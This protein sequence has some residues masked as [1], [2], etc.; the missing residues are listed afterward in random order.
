MLWTTIAVAAP[1]A[2]VT[3]VSGPLAVRKSDDSIKSI[4]IGS[5][6]DEGDTVVTQNRTYARLKFVDGSEITLKPNSQFSVESFSYDQDKPKD[7]AAK[8]SLIKGGLRTITGQIGKRVNKDSYKMKT[9]A[10]TIGIRGTM[11]ELSYCQT[12]SITGQDDGCGDV[13]PGLYLAV[14]DG[15]VVITNSEGKKTSLAVSAGQHVYV[16]DSTTSPV[17]L[18][19]KPDISFNPPACIGLSGGVQGHESS[20]GSTN[21]DMR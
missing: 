2:T 13:P 18:P 16:K 19:S 20:Y 5:K 8:F 1:V 10:A 14:T 12:V 6:L 11:Y 7:D 3:H 4:S 17:L 21:C 9:P 15:S